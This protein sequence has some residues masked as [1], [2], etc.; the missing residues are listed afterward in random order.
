MAKSLSARSWDTMENPR[1][2]LFQAVYREAIGFRRRRARH[3]A[4]PWHTLAPAGS[5]GEHV[6]GDPQVVAAV[7]ALPVRQ[8][9]VVVLTYWQDLTVGQV[10]EHLG[11]SDGAVRK[12]LARARA[13]LRSS[14]TEDGQR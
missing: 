2:Y 10:A 5:T 4:L 7:A 1:A 6:P 8:R 12:H 13:S 3:D 9:A 14:L 11:V